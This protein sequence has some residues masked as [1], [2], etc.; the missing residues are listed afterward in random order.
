GFEGHSRLCAS[1]KF[2]CC[3]IQ[4]F[5]ARSLHSARKEKTAEADLG[6]HRLS[7][8]PLSARYCWICWIPFLAKTCGGRLATADP[9]T[10]ANGGSYSKNRGAMAPGGARR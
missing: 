6:R 1:S 2:T 8:W 3:P 7:R 10:G 4:P 5:T 9:G